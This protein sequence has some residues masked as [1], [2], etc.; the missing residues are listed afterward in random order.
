M[1]SSRR[2]Y[3]N[4]LE[5]DEY[6]RF[7]HKGSV[8]EKLKAGKCWNYNVWLRKCE[9]WYNC[10]KTPIASILYLF[11]R[12]RLRQL[13]EDIGWEIPPNVF[14]P[15]LCVVHRGTVVVSPHTKVGENCRMH[16]CVNIGAW[17]GEKAA[18][19]M[20]DNIYI[21]PGAKVFGAI[22]IPSG[23][24]IGANAVVN[25][26]ICEKNVSVGGV[27]AKVLSRKGSV[28][29]NYCDEVWPDRLR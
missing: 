14:G 12:I 7:G 26:T 21:G 4:Y 9:Y 6:A 5:C 2:E 25:K 27:P 22:S 16:V 8:F 11:C 3:R 1:I 18:P 29:I 17:G 23:V 10:G 20:G 15:G 13:G 24:A 28:H 19:V